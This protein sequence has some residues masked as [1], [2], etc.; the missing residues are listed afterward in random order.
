MGDHDD[1][2]AFFVELF[3]EAYHLGSR[4]RVKVA[5]G[6]VGEDDGWIIGQHPGKRHPLL[7]TDAQL[8]RFVIH[9]VP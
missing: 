6:L 2:P 7:L 8:G 4:L 3:E 1:R 9:A 5:R